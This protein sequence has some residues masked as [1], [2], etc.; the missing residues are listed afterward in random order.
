MLRLYFF[1]GVLV[2]ASAV[3][4]KVELIPPGASLQIAS[5]FAAGLLLLRGIKANGQV[6]VGA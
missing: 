1:C 2:Q 3:H 6:F 4:R 5:V